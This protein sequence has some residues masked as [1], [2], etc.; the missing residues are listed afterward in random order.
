MRPSRGNEGARRVRKPLLVATLLSLTACAGAP[1]ERPGVDDVPDEWWGPA[2]GDVTPD[3]LAIFDAPWLEDLVAGAI[4]RNHALAQRRATLDIARQRVRLARAARLPGVNV[5]LSGQRGRATG[6]Q[7]I[8]DWF[9]VSATA[10]LTLDLWGRLGDV[11]RGALLA[12]GAEEARYRAAEQRLAADVVSAA[13]DVAAA[14]RLQA[15]L[16]RRLHNLAQSLDVIEASYR[17]GLKP[18]LDVYLARN[19]LERERANVADQ[20]QRLMQAG[21]AL[22]LLMADYPDGRFPIGEDLPEPEARVAAG[23]PA[24]LLVRRPDIQEAWLELLAADAALA[25]AHKDRFPGVGLSVSARDGADAIGRL[26]DGGALAW[27]AA[28]SLIQPLYQGGRLSALHEQARLRLVQS[29]RGYLETVYRAF[30]EV[31]VELNRTASLE[32]RLAAIIDAG[33]NAE[34]ALTLAFDQYQRGLVDY[35][36]VL[37]SQ[38]RAFDAQTAVV[39]LRNQLLQSRAAL[40]L[41]LGAG[42]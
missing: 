17:S 15:L 13:F 14:N 36:A 24:E 35:I 42:F 1:P 18:A 37:E 11:E 30:S 23:A 21:A 33:A 8:L 41:A 39:E 22:E 25:V 10:D 29:E 12:L 9:D 20:R 28:A 40:L 2:A 7:P 5:A 4:V 19:T 27:T 34:A 38:R 16:D 32:T 6:S 3:G 31:E 26:F